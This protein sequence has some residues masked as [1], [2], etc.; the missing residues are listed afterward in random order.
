MP[1]RRAE[2]SRAGLDSGDGV[3]DTQV[4][5][6]ERETIAREGLSPTMRAVSARAGYMMG[7]CVTASWA[8]EQAVAWEG[9]LELSR[10]LRRDAEGQLEEQHGLS[11]SMLGIMGRLR[12]A[13]EKRLRQTDLAEA[14][15][16]SLSRVSRLIDTLE[17]RA[18]VLRTA[19]PSDA[20]ATHVLLTDEGDAQAA[21]AQ[22]T[23]HA[24]VEAAFLGQLSPEELSTLAAVFSRLISLDSRAVGCSGE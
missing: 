20:R 3:R 18:L 22:A 15:G 4:M 10:R 23:V 14:M 24:Y 21:E 17:S 16:L 8:P 7:D 9:F 11:I 13:P 1:A 12:C 6:L 5:A 19:C 2:R